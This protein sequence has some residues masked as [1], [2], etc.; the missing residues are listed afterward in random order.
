MDKGF[1][2]SLLFA[3]VG[4]GP[5]GL[6]VASHLRAAG[7]EVRVFGKAMDF[8]DS[9]M[10]KGMLLR[11]PWDGSHLAD[12]EQ[13][14]TLDRY[15]QS[16]GKQLSRRMP[17]E[18]F[19]RYGKWFQAHAVPD[20]D[21]RHVAAVER[22]ADGFQL[23][24][25][26]GDRVWLD[27]VVIAA[28]IGSFPNIPAVFSTLPAELVSHTSAPA[29]RD[30]RR[31]ASR[32]V[33][34]VGGG[35]SAIETAAL[36]QEGGAC[37]QVVMRQPAL[38]W[39]KNRPRIERLMDSKANP[40]KAP[41]KIGPLGINWLIEHPFLFTGFPRGMQS[42][43][44]YRAIRPAASGWLHQRFAGIPVVAGREI[45]AADTQGSKA[46]LRLRDGSEH[47]ADHVLL[48]T[49]YKVDLA[50]YSFL[51]PALRGAVRT[52]GGYPLLNRG[53][54]SSVPGLYFVGATAAHSFGPLCRFVAGTRFTALTLTRYARGKPR[55]RIPALPCETK[56]GQR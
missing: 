2:S 45:V 7:L 31:F 1:S 37:V 54:E 20:L 4:A 23:T 14:W 11:S 28:G 3:V 6:S 32:H 16:Q 46:R 56:E 34:V 30:L 38:R 53:F 50:K 41:G 44:T 51:S 47:A 29:N 55:L 17:L 25:E 48:G 5:Y 35:Q 36:L 39:L 52:E 27:G 18:E 43:M 13:K 8:W 40:F 24:L 12:P 49:G 21:A 15:E 19:V 22:A 10:P 26:D 9:Q 33:L 42:W